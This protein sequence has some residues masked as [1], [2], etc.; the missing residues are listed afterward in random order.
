M[1]DRDSHWKQIYRMMLFSDRTTHTFVYHGCYFFACWLHQQRWIEPARTSTLHSNGIFFKHSKWE[2][3]FYYHIVW[4][5]LYNDE[6][7][8]TTLPSHVFILLVVCWLWLT[9]AL[10]IVAFNLFSISISLEC[11]KC[12]YNDYDNDMWDFFTFNLRFIAIWPVRA[13]CA[14]TL[15]HTCWSY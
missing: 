1:S 15:S 3:L 6:N 5:W 13:W 7:D 12:L 2:A 14:R 9:L 8:E 4:R 10:L 11:E